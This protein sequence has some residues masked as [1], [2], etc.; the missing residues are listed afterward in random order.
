MNRALPPPP[1]NTRTRIF[2]YTYTH[3]HTHANAVIIYT[4]INTYTNS[5]FAERK[6]DH[7]SFSFAYIYL[8]TP[9]TWFISFGYVFEL[10]PTYIITY[11]AM[12]MMI[13]ICTIRAPSRRVITQYLW[14]VRGR[15][16]SSYS[17]IMLEHSKANE[18]TWVEVSV[19]NIPSDQNPTVNADNIRRV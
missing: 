18:S 7:L 6:N 13:I 3:T 10:V 2:I 5:C 15:Y 19:F 9:T 11:N 4:C 16:I 17:V 1:L 12:I 14:E 8:Y